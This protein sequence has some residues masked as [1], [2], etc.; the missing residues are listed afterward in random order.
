[1]SRTLGAAAVL[2]AA[3]LASP[4]ALADDTSP[5]V[6][7]GGV[8]SQPPGSVAARSTQVA[9]EGDA[10][11]V[12]LS[13]VAA[14]PALLSLR[15]PKFEWLGDA[16][17]Y[18]ARQFPELAVTTDSRPADLASQARATMGGD[19]ITA[20]LE[21]AGLDPFAIADAP[22]IVEPGR[23]HAAFD[24]L[25][26]RRAVDRLQDV[27]LAKWSAERT[28]TWPAGAA[29]DHTVTLAYASRPSYRLSPLSA[30][31]RAAPLA[32][33]CVTQDRLA[34]AMGANGPAEAIVRVYAI[35][36]GID[37]RSGALTVSVK[38]AFAAFCGRD[39]APVL[40]KNAAGPARA[41]SRSV[42]RVVTLSPPGT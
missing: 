42:L 28:V 22:P 11:T 41:D 31:D 32:A 35:P 24:R 4:A 34:R 10:A 2:A 33:F 30:L 5:G 13:V 39:G 27:Y 23:D 14:A 9:L 15:T 29:G 37:G 1:M 7:I 16:A 12:T 6:A 20:L 3:F 26:A 17:I 25:V 40:G 38:A 21:Q 18:P 8:T 36:V 19:D